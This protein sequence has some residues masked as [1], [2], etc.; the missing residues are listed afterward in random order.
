M[1]F[2]D[3]GDLKKLI[4]QRQKEKKPFTE[5]EAI[6]FFKQIAAGLKVLHDQ[7]IVHRD[8]KPENIFLTVF[9]NFKIRWKFQNLELKKN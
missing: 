2:Y 1:E 8:L 7:D 5:S 3:S 9:F 4:Q 6:D